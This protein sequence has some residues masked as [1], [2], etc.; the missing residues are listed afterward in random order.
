[1]EDQGDFQIMGQPVDRGPD[2]GD[3][4][5][6]HERGV[7]TRPITGKFP[8]A[9]PVVRAIA[10]SVQGDRGMTA[11]PAVMV[12]AEIGEGGEEPRTEFCVGPEAGAL[13]VE[14]NE[15]LC[16]QIMRISRVLDI[17]VGE[18]MQGPLPAGHQAVERGCFALLERKQTGLID[19]GVGGHGA[20]GGRI[21]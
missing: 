21:S 2:G 13:L 4:F 14:A 18:M 17:A 10:G 3:R 19:G 12:V 16:D 8:S 5:V 20:R 1:M 7:G 6:V 11:L 9:A 15:G